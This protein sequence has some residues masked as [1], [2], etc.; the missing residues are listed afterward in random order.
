MKQQRVAGVTC[1][2]CHGQ[3]GTQLKRKNSKIPA[4]ELGYKVSAKDYYDIFVTCGFYK[5]F[6]HIN[7]MLLSHFSAIVA[8]DAVMQ[9]AQIKRGKRG[10]WVAMKVI[11]FIIHLKSVFI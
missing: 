2:E 7:F 3:V 4:K 1:L 10:G 5:V 11:Q 8:T 6:V 9:K